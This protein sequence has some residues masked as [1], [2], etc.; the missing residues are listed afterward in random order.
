MQIMK[1]IRG[2][3]VVLALTVGAIQC[4]HSADTPLTLDNTSTLLV[5][6][7]EDSIEG[8]VFVSKTGQ[9]LAL[10]DAA[11]GKSQKCETMVLALMKAHNFTVLH[12]AASEC[13]AAK[14]PGVSL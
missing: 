2:A 4:A 6:Q 5:L 1:F 3:L 14:S 12:I 10:S 11:C 9:T 13:P 8:Y 7:L